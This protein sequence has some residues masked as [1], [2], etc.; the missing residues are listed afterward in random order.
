M[1]GPGQIPGRYNIVSAD[2]YETIDHQV[3]VEDFL[4]QLRNHEVPESICVVGLDDAFA[5]DDFIDELADAMADRA[6]DLENRHPLPTI[7]FAIDGALHRRKKT[8]DLRYDGEF[9]SLQRLFGSQIDREGEDWVT[10]PF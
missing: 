3:P 1:A 7:Q 4:D 2:E 8:Y 5:D 6:N 9:H 10:A